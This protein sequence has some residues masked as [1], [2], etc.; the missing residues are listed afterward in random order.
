[1]LGEAQ[2]LKVANS[3]YQSEGALQDGGKISF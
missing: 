2:K 1:M 3:R